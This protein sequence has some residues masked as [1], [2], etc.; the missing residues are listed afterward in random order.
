MKKAGLT[1]RLIAAILALSLLPVPAQRDGVHR[2]LQRPGHGAG[3]ADH[4]LLGGRSQGRGN[5]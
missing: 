3:G 4:R 5:R 2:Y 1:A